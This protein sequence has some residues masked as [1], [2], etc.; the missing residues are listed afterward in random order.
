MMLSAT[1][2]SIVPRIHHREPSCSCCIRPL[3]IRAMVPE[4]IG[5]LLDSLSR[6]FA[7]T[8]SV[9][10]L[11][12]QARNTSKIP[13]LKKYRKIVQVSMNIFPNHSNFRITERGKRSQ[14]CN[15]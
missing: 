13:T 10:A 1:R 15:Y 12:M 5:F 2:R 9:N 7:L 3:N 14:K 8:C 4:A 11:A 6:P